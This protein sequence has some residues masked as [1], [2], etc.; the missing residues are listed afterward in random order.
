MPGCR[1]GDFW[2]ISVGREGD[3]NSAARAGLGNLGTSGSLYSGEI[4]SASDTRNL[5]FNSADDRIRRCP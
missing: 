3:K 4:P 2:S 5:L 1:Q